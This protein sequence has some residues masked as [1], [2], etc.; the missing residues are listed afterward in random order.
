[1]VGPS[2]CG[3][4]YG[5]FFAMGVSQVRWVAFGYSLAFGDPVNA[6]LIGNLASSV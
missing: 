2:T 5:D 3:H 4:A 6:A 1:M